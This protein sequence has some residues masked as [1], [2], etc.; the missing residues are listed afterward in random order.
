[1]RAFP[2]AGLALLLTFALV[3]A[4]DKSPLK[5][6]QDKISYS[7]G[8]RI[9]R[10]FKGQGIEIAPDALIRGVRDAMEGNT[11]LLSD[12]EIRMVMFAF[13]MEQRGKQQE[14][15]QQIGEKNKRE[16]EA[17]LAKNRQ[18]PG[19]TTA[20]S[21]LQ[22]KVITEGTGKSPSVN[23]T[24]TAHYKGTLIDGTVFDN[25]YDRGEPAR[26]SVSG[27]IPGWT[28]ALQMMKVGAKWMLWIPAQLAYGERGT[29]QHIGPNT[30]LIF[31]IELIAIE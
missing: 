2:L 4:Q 11:T 18:K 9:G 17:F 30:A 20:A 26:L 27:V 8:L 31:E 10:N 6:Q 1:M 22:Y 28:E 13:Q 21:G 23:D 14:R 24:V 19:V 7:I 15:S 16:G 29:G 12:E 3:A 5:S 25:S